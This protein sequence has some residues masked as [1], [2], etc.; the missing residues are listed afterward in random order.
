MADRISHARGWFLKAESD[1]SAARRVLDG[2]GPFDTA[3]FHAQQPPKSSSRDSWPFM[4]SPSRTRTTLRNSPACA[5]RSIQAW[6]SVA[7]M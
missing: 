4:I 1:L 2:E 7:W 6:I 5:A 3:C